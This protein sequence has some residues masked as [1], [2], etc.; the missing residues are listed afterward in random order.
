MIYPK[1]QMGAKGI[2]DPRRY[3]KPNALGANKSDQPAGFIHHIEW[4]WFDNSVILF[5]EE[6]GR[7]KIGNAIN[8]NTRGRF[9]S[10]EASGFDEAFGKDKIDVTKIATS[11]SEYEPE[12]ARFHW[13]RG[14]YN[15][16]HGEEAFQRDTNH[17]DYEAQINSIG[18]AEFS[19][20]ANLKSRD[21]NLMA[22]HSK[23]YYTWTWVLFPKSEFYSFKLGGTKSDVIKIFGVPDGD[24]NNPGTKKAIKVLLYRTTGGHRT[25]AWNFFYDD[26][27]IIIRKYI[28]DETS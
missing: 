8:G 11:R 4:G 5:L 12:A 22:V 17:L 15:V 26:H 19:G 20:P 24:Y 13:M 6:I 25:Y 3:N 28:E 2:E 18:R 14:I 7:D 27:G 1:V 23:Q 21:N 10:Y 16:E 9:F